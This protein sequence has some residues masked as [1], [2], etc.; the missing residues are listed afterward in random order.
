MTTTTTTT[1]LESKQSNRRESA[2][3]G[4][5]KMIFLE[6]LINGEQD[7]KKFQDRICRLPAIHF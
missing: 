5:T 3:T 7:K 6:S 1:N 4:S 2:T